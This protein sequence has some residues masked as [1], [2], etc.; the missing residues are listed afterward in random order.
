M[1]NTYLKAAVLTAALALLGFFFMSQL[2]A[3]R[4][5]EL[6][7]SV[8]DLTFQSESEQLLFLYLQTMENNSGEVCGYLS[9]MTRDKA[10]KAW[11]LSEKI[12][13]YEKS[14][15]ASG[16]YDRIRR[17]YYLANAELYL[18]MRAAE[19][20]CGQSQYNT[21][22]FFYSINSNCPECRAQGGVLDNLRKTHPEMQVFAFPYDSGEP[23][24]DIFVKRHGIASVPAVVVNDGT[25]LTGLQSESQIENQFPKR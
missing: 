25:V 16:D 17:Q 9:Q 23:F 11:A 6:R 12:Q 4:A 7:Q 24:L 15:V 13:Y 2:D 1:A 3:M 21:V 20:Y 10:N 22:L 14:N 19:K 8:D 18:N 5:A